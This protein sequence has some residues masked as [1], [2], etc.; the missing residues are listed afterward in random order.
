LEEGNWIDMAG[1]PLIAAEG[2]V[3]EDGATEGAEGVGVEAGQGGDA[4]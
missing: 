3:A 1:I 4:E 2:A